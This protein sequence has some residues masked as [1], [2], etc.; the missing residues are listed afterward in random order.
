MGFWYAEVPTNANT[1]IVVTWANTGANPPTYALSCVYRV[2]RQQSSTPQV[3]MASQGFAGLNN[4]S[5]TVNA[6]AGGVIIFACE[7]A[8]F[9]RHTWTGVTRDATFD[10]NVHSPN[11]TMEWCSAAFNT[12]QS[13]LTITG[14]P[15][16]SSGRSTLGAVWR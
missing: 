1:D 7:G 12:A 16:I 9:E 13:P 5:R 2:T 3:A 4:V 8:V 6:Q 10:D 14:V 11:G 15:N